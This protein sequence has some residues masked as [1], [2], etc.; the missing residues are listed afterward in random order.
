MAEVLK[1]QVEALALNAAA[2]T[3]LLSLYA[4]HEGF[5]GGKLRETISELEVVAAE[6]LERVRGQRSETDSLGK[7]K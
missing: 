2:Q 4:K 1:R 5:G 6:A 3:T 7:A